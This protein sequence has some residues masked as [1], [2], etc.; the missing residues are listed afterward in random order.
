MWKSGVV[1]DA[2]GDLDLRRG[3]VGHG[4]GGLARGRPHHI[5]GRSRRGR[6]ASR[7]NR[8]RGNAAL[9]RGKLGLERCP[10]RSN[11]SRRDSSPAPSSTAR[12]SAI[13]AVIA[14]PAPSLSPL[15]ERG[16]KRLRIAGEARHRA[17]HITGAGLAAV[18]AERVENR[19]GAIAE[20]LRVEVDVIAV[21]GF[22]GIDTRH[23]DERDR[24][25]ESCPALSGGRHQR[26][27]YAK[28]LDLK[29][30]V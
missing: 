30:A 27:S 29:T 16:R 8:S 28:T 4:R 26:E 21:R 25:R 13:S 10:F 17:H 18:T 15:R 11:R 5:G 24:D 23:E 3:A 6:D 2:A 19:E 22:G 7:S 20:M 12:R 14:A 9:N 1:G